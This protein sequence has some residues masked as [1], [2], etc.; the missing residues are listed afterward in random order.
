M[1]DVHYS[2]PLLTL[3]FLSCVYGNETVKSYYSLSINVHI[4][5]PFF[6]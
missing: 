3:I 4:V 2:F 6:T 5:V 1:T